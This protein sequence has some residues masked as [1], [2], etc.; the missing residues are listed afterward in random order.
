MFQEAHLLKYSQILLS[1]RSSISASSR[2]A[3][4]KVQNSTEHVLEMLFPLQP[5]HFGGYDWTFSRQE[6]GG[7]LRKA[8]INCRT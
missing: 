4:F 8:S 7:F 6:Q 3:N 2:S 1:I 5:H